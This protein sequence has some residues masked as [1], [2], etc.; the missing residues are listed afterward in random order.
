MHTYLPK[1]NKKLESFLRWFMSA[2]IKNKAFIKNDRR[3]RIISKVCLKKCKYAFI[4]LYACIIIWQWN[5][6]SPLS[7]SPSKTCCLVFDTFICKHHKFHEKF[8]PDVCIQVT[9]WDIF[10]CNAQMCGSQENFSKQ[11]HMRVTETAVCQ[12][13][14]AEQTCDQE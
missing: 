14:P 11:N 9:S 6:I 2:K 1:R 8:S 7:C 12:N 5:Y 3:T 13:L 10:Q 4:L